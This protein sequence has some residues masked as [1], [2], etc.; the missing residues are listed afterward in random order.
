VE[1]ENPPATPQP[2]N[3]CLEIPKETYRE[4][5]IDKSGPIEGAGF[6]PARGLPR[7]HARQV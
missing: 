7:Q 2:T 3:Q 4:S 6:T 5:R 1:A